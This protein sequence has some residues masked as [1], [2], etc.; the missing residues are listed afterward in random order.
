[1]TH[2]KF[3]LLSM[4]PPFFLMIKI[5][6]GSIFIP[7]QFVLDHQP[8]MHEK[9]K[10][11]EFFMVLCI[12]YILCRLYI[13]SKIDATSFKAH[14]MF[15]LMES[16]IFSQALKKY[17]LTLSQVRF[18]RRISGHANSYHLPVLFYMLLQRNFD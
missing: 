8:C 12:L 14:L 7:S 18:P 6:K 3:V 13:V 10:F 11:T 9:E 4:V 17:P 5:V 16:P 2:F 1:M 15:F